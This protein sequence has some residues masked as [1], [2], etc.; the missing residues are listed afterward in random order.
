MT[1]QINESVVRNVFNSGNLDGNLCWNHIV[2]V[3][4]E[5]KNTIYINGEVL[6]EKESTNP[7]FL[8]MDAT[9]SIANST[10]NGLSSHRFHGNIDEFRI[11]DRALSI[12]EIRTLLVIQDQILSTDTV[13][14]AG[15]FVQIESA[16][17]CAMN[18]SWTPVSDVSN[19][20]ILEPRLTPA[21][22]T[23]Y[24]L[25]MNHDLCTTYDEINITVVDPSL[26]NC[27]N[28]FLAKAF[29][30]NG[31]GIND[32]F[33]ISNPYVLE[34]M[35]TFEIYDRWGGRMFST[36]EP[37]GKWDG[38]YKGEPVNPGTYFYVVSSICEGKNVKTSGNVT[39]LR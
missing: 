16:P 15:S 4:N 9:L 3:K 7:L 39:V 24:T 22:T 35:V 38:S 33:G 6:S 29:T 26:L 5:R 2:Y 19:V 17:S 8:F 31:D 36:T 14:T 30:P 20:G 1:G 28:I 32:Q 37:F 10:C 21:Q 18:V 11:Y 25:E 13:I 27:N 34:Q 12:E 23:K